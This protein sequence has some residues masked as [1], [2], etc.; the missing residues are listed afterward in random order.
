MAA[1]LTPNR[2]L[3]QVDVQADFMLPG[4]KL[5]V[6]GAERII[7]QVKKLAEAARQNRV[8]M[9]SSGDQHAPDDP[10]F[11][12]F[13]PHCVRYTPGADLLPEARAAKILRVPNNPAFALPPDLAAYQQV[14]IEKQTLDVFDNPH[15]EEILERLPRD[16]TFTVYGVVTEYCVRCAAAGLLGRGKRVSIV[17][18]AI[19][20]LDAQSGKKTIEELQA[21]G[22]NLLTTEEAWNL[23]NAAPAGTLPSSAA[24]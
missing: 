18:D 20:T 4:G 21:R 17:T 23:L 15:T 16:V 19:E 8:L 3:W 14:L 9:I 7:P 12:R 1:K 24:S 13:P 6:P 11:A 22:A 10:E 2:I 5:Y